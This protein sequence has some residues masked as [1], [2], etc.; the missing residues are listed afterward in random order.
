MLSCSPTE[1]SHGLCMAE[2]FT[3]ARRVVAN[4]YPVLY[5]I[6]VWIGT[7]AFGFTTFYGLY[8]L[9]FIPEIPANEP[10]IREVVIEGGAAIVAIGLTSLIFLAKSLCRNR[11]IAVP[12]SRRFDNQH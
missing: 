7:V 4:K 1:T 2:T 10:E 9:S 8:I 11:E 5:T 12:S 6:L 3:N